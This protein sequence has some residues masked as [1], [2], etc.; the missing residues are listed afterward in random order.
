MEIV[1]I[2]RGKT[3]ADAK[4]GLEKVAVDVAVRG[5]RATVETKYPEDLHPDYAVSVAYNVTA[6]AGTKVSLDSIGGH[7][8]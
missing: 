4:A 2:S 7:C 1:R 5:E 3:E 8:R 6:P